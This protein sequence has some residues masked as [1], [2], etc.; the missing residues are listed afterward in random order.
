MASDETCVWNGASGTNYTYYVW[1]RHPNIDPNQFGN[2][3]YSKKNAQGLWVP[4]YIG[5]GDLS[6]RCTNSHHQQDCINLK[7]A[8]HVHL[9]LNAQERDRLAEERDLLARYTNAYASEGC[10][11][12]LG[13]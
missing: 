6:V 11:V 3:I 8:T 4:I 13:G 1:P 9:H 2:Y 10:N 12:K 5:Q 7:G